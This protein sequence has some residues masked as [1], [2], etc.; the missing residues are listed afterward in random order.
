MDTTMITEVT[1]GRSVPE[2]YA[3]RTFEILRTSTPGNRTHKGA[4]IGKKR[5]D[6]NIVI[7]GLLKT[8]TVSTAGKQQA[9]QSLMLCAIMRLWPFESAAT[10]GSIATCI[11]SGTS[12]IRDVNAIATEKRPSW[13]VFTAEKLSTIVAI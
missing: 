13:L 1:C 12:K 4:K 5:E 3:G 10:L 2:K 7:M 8:K 11:A 9:K 6:N